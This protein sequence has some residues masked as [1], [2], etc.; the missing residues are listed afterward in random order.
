[1]TLPLRTAG[2]R[3]R[4]ANLVPARA[5]FPER[6]IDARAAL[7]VLLV[8]SLSAAFGFF[9]LWRARPH[10][11]EVG[12]VPAAVVVAPVAPEQ[13][14]FVGAALAATP[15]PTP[16]AV[17]PADR[18]IVVDVQGRVRRPGTVNLPSGARVR[19]ALNA[20]GGPKDGAS[21]RSLNLAAPLTD[22]EQIVL[23]PDCPGPAAPNVAGT[24]PAAA[25]ATPSTSSPAVPPWGKPSAKPVPAP[26]P[27][28]LDLNRATAAELD[29]LPGIGPVLA[30]RIVAYRTTHGRF[31]S[32]DELREVNGI[33]AAKLAEIR[34][35][36]R[37]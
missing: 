14:S 26:A 29:T 27:A 25:A 21:T 2:L 35:R 13:R 33:G 15:S 4:L 28:V 30:D 17:A 11:A 19:D 23:G 3:A 8:A 12:P 24:A 5:A 20:A 32:V 31:T 16:S 10:S 22:G 7:V 9:L 6:G 18:G 36:V 34:S 37:V 1:M